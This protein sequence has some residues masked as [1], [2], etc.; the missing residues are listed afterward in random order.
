VAGLESA[1]VWTTVE[2]DYGNSVS[3]QSTE[4]SFKKGGNG[5]L[6]ERNGGPVDL[7]AFHI[8][9]YFRMYGANRSR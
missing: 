5:P 6:L 9:W 1:T 2:S 3:V 7:S 8:V 4:D